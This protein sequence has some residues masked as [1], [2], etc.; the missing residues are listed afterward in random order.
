MTREPLRHLMQSSLHRGDVQQTTHACIGT[1]RVLRTSTCACRNGRTAIGMRSWTN[2][3]ARSVWP[4]QTDA[5][6]IQDMTDGRERERESCL[7]SIRNLSPAHPKPVRGAGEKT[8]KGNGL[9]ARYF[10]SLAA[11]GSRAVPSE[12]GPAALCKSDSIRGRARPVHRSF[13]LLYS[14]PRDA[15]RA[16]CRVESSRR[17]TEPG[18]WER[19]MDGRAR[20]TRR[21]LTTHERADG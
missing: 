12:V 7:Q 6:C 2:V 18:S 3:T 17:S 11:A 9:T 5:T 20:I 19:E 13:T 14:I 8:E 4:E 1:V 10:W 21:R 16:P 15:L